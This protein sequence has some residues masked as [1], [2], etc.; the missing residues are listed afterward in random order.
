MD[1]GDY[2]LHL[3]TRPMKPLLKKETGDPMVYMIVVRLLSAFKQAID[4]SI[5]AL[6]GTST[7][8]GMVDGGTEDMRT[9]GGRACIRQGG[10][11]HPP[12]SV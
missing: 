1:V 6:G 3:G 7:S 12:S 10:I 9:G 11:G 4:T 8:T 5:V 2:S